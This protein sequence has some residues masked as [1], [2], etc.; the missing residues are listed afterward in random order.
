MITVK[1][2][3]DD[4]NEVMQ[5]VV[6]AIENLTE[7]KD[8]VDISDT[9]TYDESGNC[10]LAVDNESVYFENDSKGCDYSIHELSFWDG[11]KVIEAI[12][13]VQK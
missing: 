11:I 8:K 12:Q 1:N 3:I 10:I 7:G 2:L 13:K 9:A 4:F 5:D 6:L